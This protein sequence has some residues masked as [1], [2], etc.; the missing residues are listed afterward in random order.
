MRKNEREQRPEQPGLPTQ[1]YH[2]RGA[3]CRPQSQIAHDQH[4]DVARVE[5]EQP[6][7]RG[8]L[9]VE[10]DRISYQ[11][12]HREHPLVEAGLHLLGNLNLCV[13]QKPVE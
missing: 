9:V 1:I 3:G 10:L 5:H 2:L 7:A 6:L 12:H 11:R 8:H 4:V 13:A